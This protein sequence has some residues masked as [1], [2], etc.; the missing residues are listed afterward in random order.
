MMLRDRRGPLAALLLALA[1]LLVAIA[2]LEYALAAMGLI[3][4]TPL[5]PTLSALLWTNFAA[6]LWRVAARSLFTAREFG[7]AQGVMAV[8]RTV[9]SNTIAIIAGRRA[10]AAYARTLRGGR[11]VWDKTEHSDHPASALA[12]SDDHVR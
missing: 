9:V 3:A 8:P 5:S 10:M 12:S 2:A 6:L 7:W 1:Y 11:P 4:R